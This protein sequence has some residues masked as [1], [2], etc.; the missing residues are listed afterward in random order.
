MYLLSV[1]SQHQIQNFRSIGWG[2]GRYGPPNF[3]IFSK[4]GV[5]GL[6]LN[7]CISGPNGSI[8]TKFV[9]LER[10]FNKDSNLLPFW[11]F[12]HVGVLWTLDLRFSLLNRSLPSPLRYLGVHVE[13]WLNRLT[14]IRMSLPRRIQRSSLLSI[15]TTTL[16][17]N[18]A[19]QEFRL[20][21]SL[22]IDIDPKAA[23]SDYPHRSS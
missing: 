10:V 22:T 11:K 2:F 19:P 14:E 4:M 23:L 9:L 1:I 17:H 5:A 15:T 8:F 7:P 18:V 13:I 12:V 3:E 20:T 6:P 21:S 16:C